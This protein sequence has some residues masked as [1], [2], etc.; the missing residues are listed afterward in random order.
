[1]QIVWSFVNV[2]RQ[3]F[4]ALPLQSTVIVDSVL[5]LQNIKGPRE[6]K[7]GYITRENWTEHNVVS[8]LFVRIGKTGT[9]RNHL[10]KWLVLECNFQRAC[11]KVISIA[12]ARVSLLHNI[13]CKK[14]KEKKWEKKIV[15]MERGTVEGGSG[16]GFAQLPSPTLISILNEVVGL[17]SL[18]TDDDA[19]AV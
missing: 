10:E 15:I 1:M 2:Y 16:G 4:V 13:C 9:G 8:V 19:N 12:T 18:V 5:L 14:E 3:L 6:G 11:D 17:L 7:V